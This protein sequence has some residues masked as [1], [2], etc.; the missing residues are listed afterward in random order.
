MENTSPVGMRNYKN[1][2][3]KLMV[4]IWARHPPV[5][6]VFKLRLW[7]PHLTAFLCIVQVSL[8]RV[9]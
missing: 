9:P 1:T 5:T 4:A 3:R 7:L 2:V 8:K 6:R